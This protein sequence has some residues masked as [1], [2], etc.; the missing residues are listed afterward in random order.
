[1]KKNKILKISVALIGILFLSGCGGSEN[2]NRM[3][4]ENS[5]EGPVPFE[6]YSR[7][8]ENINDAVEKENDKINQAL[9]D[10]GLE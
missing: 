10:A 8:K 2:A 7:S 6:V 4:N 9:E 1:M 5:T 3:E